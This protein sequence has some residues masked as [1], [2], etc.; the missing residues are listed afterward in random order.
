MVVIVVRLALAVVAVV[1]L[2]AC[3]G[4]GDVPA[5]ATLDAA[6]TQ[7]CEHFSPLG[8]EVRRG[9]LEGPEL[10]RELQDVYDVAR[11]S[12]NED[13]DRAA[14]RLLTAAIN[15]DRRATT[16]AVTELQQACGLPFD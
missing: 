14:Q 4:G 13:I 16:A 9:E 2:A 8:G 3:S 10:Y 6:A 12:E 15:G 5:A 11:T 1:S 7:A